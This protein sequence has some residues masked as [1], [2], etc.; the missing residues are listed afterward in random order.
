MRKVLPDRLALRHIK[1]STQL[2]RLDLVDVG[3]M[4]RWDTFMIPEGAEEAGRWEAI[5]DKLR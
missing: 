1:A 3:L 5:D 4:A 2:L